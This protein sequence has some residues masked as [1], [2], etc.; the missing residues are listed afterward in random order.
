MDHQSNR[1]HSSPW[2][3]DKYHQNIFK[4]LKNLNLIYYCFSQKFKGYSFD[5][6]IDFDWADSVTKKE[7]AYSLYVFKP[8]DH[9]G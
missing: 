6:S 9:V 1:F 4:N 2:P 7:K 5:G 3:A 8:S